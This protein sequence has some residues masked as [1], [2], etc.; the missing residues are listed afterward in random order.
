MKKASESTIQTLANGGELVQAVVRHV[1]GNDV[2]DVL[3]G[4]PL[5]RQV[6]LE[7]A[8]IE[9]QSATNKYLGGR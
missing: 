1:V 6:L 7:L 9:F 5:T 8:Q 3:N 4:S 2:A